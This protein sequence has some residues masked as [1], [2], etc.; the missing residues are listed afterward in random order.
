M[1]T[2]HDFTNKSALVTGGATGI[3]KGC[4]KFLLGTG[5]HVT[6]AGPDSAAL[7]AAIAEL[8]EA[9]AQGARLEAVLCD[10]TDEEQV[11]GAVD[12]AAADGNLDIV[13]SNAGTGYP[14]PILSL[15]AEGWLLPFRV[16]V[17][18]TA[19]C[20]KH[21]AQVMRG[22]G[23][24]TI[25]AIST[26][27]ACR[28][29]MFM[30]P[31]PVSKAGVDALVRCAARELASFGI[32]VNGV[33]PGYVDTES[34][35]AAFSDEM[36]RNCLDSTWLGRAGQPLDIAQAVGFLASEHAGW[37]T[38]EMLNVD[39]GFGVHDGENFEYTARM[40]VGDA[41][42]DDAKGQP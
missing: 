25:I 32:R 17:M 38:G 27:E 20:I 18:G 22:H 37:I 36:V 29:P 11:R 8:E 1:S 24:G 3:G 15:D 12:A 40:V 23:G 35:R 2:T 4:A 14:A 42:V 41:V 34:A 19:F 33:R 21:A 5:A 39:G 7:D 9:R 16:N 28:A 26:I 13:V 31:Y 6:I 10:V 30:A